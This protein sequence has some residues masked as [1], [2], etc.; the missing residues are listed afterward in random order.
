MGVR[1]VGIGACSVRPKGSRAS[2]VYDL[3]LPKWVHPQ[4]T[5]PKYITLNP[6][7]VLQGQFMIGIVYTQR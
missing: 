4:N 2:I 5:G 7:P 6:R 1:V 3:A